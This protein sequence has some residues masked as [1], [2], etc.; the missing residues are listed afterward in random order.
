MSRF[1]W[2]SIVT[3]THY[4]YPNFL[5]KGIDPLQMQV[6]NY[7]GYPFGFFLWR[8]RF[9]YYRWCCYAFESSNCASRRGRTWRSIAWC[10]CLLIV[11]R[12]ITIQKSGAHSSWLFDMGSSIVS[13]PHALAIYL[14]F[15]PT[16]GVMLKRF[17]ECQCEDDDVRLHCQT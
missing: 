2:S 9:N 1:S 15:V 4:A 8:W 3:T 10:E 5:N 14:E 12:R 6:P 16:C 7:F 11:A 17:E 13:N